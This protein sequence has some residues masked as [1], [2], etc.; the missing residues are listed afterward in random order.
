MCGGG[1]DKAVKQQEKNEQLRQQ[2]V[3]R[4]AGQIRG[5][6]G[7]DARKAEI[8]QYEADTEAFYRKYLDQQHGNAARELNFALART[9]QGGGQVQIDKGADLTR[10]YNEGA[11]K[12]SRAA[13]QAGA[14][15]RAA[16]QDTQNRLIGMAQAGLD[17]TNSYQLALSGM[18]DN[19][20]AAKAEAIPEGLGQAFSGL[21]D[22]YQFSQEAKA[23]QRGYEQSKTGNGTPTWMSGYSGSGNTNSTPT[24]MIGGG[25]P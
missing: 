13:Q 18:R 10:N 23:Y 24:W 25:G 14:R 22:T 5:V 2:Q 6:F 19:A 1:S 12:V 9:G 20:L 3:N 4:V 16:D 17:T 7:S 15:L 11:L 21:A 8:S